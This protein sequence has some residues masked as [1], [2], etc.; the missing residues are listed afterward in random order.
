MKIFGKDGGP[1]SKVW[2]YFFE[3]KRLFS[4][5]VLR[6]EDGSREAYHS[7]AFNSINWIIKGKLVESHREGGEIM[8]LPSWKPVITRRS[9]FHKVTSE[10]RS[11]VLSF[12]G[13]WAKTWQEWIPDEQRLVTLTHGR[14]E[15]EGQ[16]GPSSI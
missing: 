5:V 8:Y 14:K 15:I 10:G 16:I 6:F 2:G 7:H 13:P 9:T 4:I 11:W 1:T 12:R 3:L